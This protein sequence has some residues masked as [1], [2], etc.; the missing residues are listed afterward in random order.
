[1]AHESYLFY[2]EYSQINNLLNELKKV[3]PI[4]F[5]AGGCPRDIYMERPFEDIDIYISPE[6][7][8]FDVINILGSIEAV[9]SINIKTEHN[10][11]TIYRT[12]HLLSVIS[13]KAFGF[14]FQV[15]TTTFKTRSSVLDTFAV[16]LSKFYFE[17]R[18]IVITREAEVDL[19]RNTLTIASPHV[20]TYYVKK[21]AKKFPDR[22]IIEFKDSGRI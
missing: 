9:T 17:G 22:K 13:F 19:D 14:D 2:K 5:I 11:P 8:I 10:I 4:A 7:N 21:I 12:P 3:S 1:M 20:N 16:S 18:N 15:I 6:A